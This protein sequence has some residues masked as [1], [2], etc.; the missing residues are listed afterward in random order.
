MRAWLAT[1]GQE[2]PADEREPRLSTREVV[3]LALVVLL[4]RVLA[5]RAFPIYDDAFITYRYARNLAEGLGMVYNPG[6]P[7]EPVLGTTTPGYTVLLAGLYAL[8]LPMIGA[9]L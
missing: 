9:S 7:W 8:G 4:A 1:L 6:A 5:A 2:P 3:L